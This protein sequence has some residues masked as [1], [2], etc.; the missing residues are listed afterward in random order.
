[1]IN[2][3]G[4]ASTSRVTRVGIAATLVVSAIVTL[5]ISRQ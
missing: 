1:M 2:G 3:D 4:T 5:M